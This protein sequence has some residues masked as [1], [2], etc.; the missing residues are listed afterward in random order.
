MSHACLVNAPVW[1]PARPRASTPSPAS[2]APESEGPFVLYELVETVGFRRGLDDYADQPAVNR[3]WG[4]LQAQLRKDPL[5]AQSRKLEG[6]R[7]DLYRSK[8]DEGRR[9]VWA[10]QKVPSSCSSSESTRRIRPGTPD[11][12]MLIMRP[13]RPV[14]RRRGPARS[15]RRRARGCSTFWPTASSCSSGSQSSKLLGAGGR[16]SSD[17]EVLR[18]TCGEESSPG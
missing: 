14:R 13:S 8:I 17:L 5:K 1:L 6:T 9:V 12:P 16:R 3:A 10:V 2:A 7:V 18:G 11:D 15:P 4:Q